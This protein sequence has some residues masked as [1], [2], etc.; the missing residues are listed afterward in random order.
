MVL[1]FEVVQMIH[2]FCP[3]LGVIIVNILTCTHTLHR[4][5][6]AT[7]HAVNQ[8]F[9]L[10]TTMTTE[11]ALNMGCAQLIQNSDSPSTKCLCF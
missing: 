3:R 8:A 9:S 5:G 4:H 2:V 7:A 6:K 1:V 10:V 11:A